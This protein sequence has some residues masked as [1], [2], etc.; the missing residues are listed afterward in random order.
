MKITSFEYESGS[1]G[2]G[3]LRLYT[4]RG[5]FDVTRR[6]GHEDNGKVTY[7]DVGGDSLRNIVTDPD[8]HE[9]LN[10]FDQQIPGYPFGFSDFWGSYATLIR[11]HYGI[12]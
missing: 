4:D 8:L 5:T 9:M 7:V 11:S 12:I 2:V 10:V 6:M 3:T 1:A